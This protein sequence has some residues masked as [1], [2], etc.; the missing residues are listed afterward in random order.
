LEWQPHLQQH[1]PGPRAFEYRRCWYVKE[2]GNMLC[3]VSAI[4]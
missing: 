3:F 1:Y 2:P 4:C